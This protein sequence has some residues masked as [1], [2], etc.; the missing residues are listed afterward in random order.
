VKIR[1]PLD[2]SK[3]NPMDVFPQGAGSGLDADTVDGLHAADISVGG[4][5]DKFQDLT[6]GPGSFVGHSGDLVKVNTGETALEYTP[7]PSGGGD[8]FKAI[9][10][11]DTDGQVEAAD[12]ADGAPWGGLTGVPST[13]PPSSHTHPITD[14][15]NGPGSMT[16]NAGKAIR[17]NSGMTAWEYA[18][19]PVTYLPDFINVK[20]AP[21]NAAGDGVTD[22]TAAIQAAENA[23][24]ASG[25]ALWFPAGTYIISSKITIY[26]YAYW[27]GVPIIPHAM[28]WTND[29]LKE[30]PTFEGFCSIIQYKQTVHGDFLYLPTALFNTVE[31]HLDGLC[32]RQGQGR[33]SADRFCV[34]SPRLMTMSRC[35]LENIETCFNNAG[36]IYAGRFRENRYIGCGTVFGSA[37]SD[38]IIEDS[39]FT[40]CGE[41]LY[42]I[43]GPVRF[44]NCRLEWCTRGIRSIGG[45]R[46]ILND[47]EI[48]TIAYSGVDLKNT[49]DFVVSGCYFTANGYGGYGGADGAHIAIRGVCTGTIGDS[50]FRW[51][52]DSGVGHPDYVFGFD[53]CTG[54][55]ITVKN[56]KTAASHIKQP[57]YDVASNSQNFLDIDFVELT[58]EAI[59]GGGYAGD[60]NGA[61]DVLAA[62]ITILNRAA[63]AGVEGRIN[64][65]GNRKL[66]AAAVG[67]HVYITSP[68]GSVYDIGSP[69]GTYFNRLNNITLGGSGP[70]FKDDGG[71]TSANSIP[72]AGYWWP[73]KLVTNRSVI[74]TGTW[75]WIYTTSSSWRALT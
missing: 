71:N 51:H 60:P 39:F 28:D 74:G 62:T 36:Y 54:S 73:G 7:F 25:G 44:D 12:W 57:F 14:L 48:D 22:D 38:V 21:Y 55:K 24:H 29:W 37:A 75:G 70:T 47:C 68:N 72:A 49:T 41:C 32:F 43:S 27:A 3:L 50:T 67:R 8:M 30:H 1:S 52:E 64:I 35:R 16:G 66:I 56:L 33:T 26:P 11:P 40:S 20:D 18:N 2:R 59:P 10:D 34:P 4:G 69:S 46:L 63:V 61:N 5:V 17:V 19:F 15:S 31:I 53:N 9:Y 45:S 13:F 65:Y 23:R 58:G 6:D 42:H